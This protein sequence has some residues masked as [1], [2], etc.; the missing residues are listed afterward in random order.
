MP[1]VVWVLMP[2][3][4]ALGSALVTAA[5]MQARV[6]IAA[7][8][9]RETLA[10][11]RALLATHHRVMEDRIRAAEETARREAL[12]EVLADLRVEERQ[13][14]RQT[15]PLRTLVVAQERLCFRNIPLTGWTTRELPGQDARPAM[16]QALLP[17]H[18][19]ADG[20]YE[21]KACVKAA[22]GMGR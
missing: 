15:A 19:H 9:H 8:R 4:I 11:A 3:L 6:E 7:G 21:E 10:E 16:L 2:V 17:H 20:N 12:D 13:F 22:N 14:V 18:H 1:A 5:L